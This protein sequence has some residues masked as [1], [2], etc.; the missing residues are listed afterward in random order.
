MFDAHGKNLAR[1]GAVV[2]LAGAAAG[3]TLAAAGPAA[4][5]DSSGVA[6]LGSFEHD[7][8]VT[9]PGQGAG[10]AGTV[11]LWYQGQKLTVYCIDI[12][13]PTHNG[14][15]YTETDWA[16]S[17]LSS[18]PDAGKIQWI[19]DHSYPSV[20]ASALAASA[21]LTGGLSQDEAAAGTQIAIWHY[22]DGV[23][24][25]SSDPRTS[26][27]A[28][29]L[30]QNAVQESQPQ[31]SLQLS[32]SNVAGTT[33]GRVGPI[34]VSTSASSVS[35]Q[36]SAPA[37]VSLSNSAG[38]SVQ[39]AVNNEQLY[40]NVPAG[41]APGD[42][43]VSASAT[44]DIPV[45]RAFTP[46][47]GLSQTMILAGTSPVSVS[48]VAQAQW[49]AAS[50]V[51]PAANAAADCKQGGIDVTLSNA[52]GQAWTTAV[53]G[54]SVTVPAGGSR[55][56]LVPVKQGATYRITVTGPNGFSKTFTGALKCQTSGPSAAPSASAAAGAPTP[57]ATP[58]GPGLAETGASSATPMI[59]G[60]GAALV[61]AGAGGVFLVRRRRNGRHAA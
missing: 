36:L 31:P 20:S 44:T 24:A 60:V 28:A 8:S 33:G 50:G 4:A 61:I 38:Q 16:D 51:V 35:L 45:G 11:A 59:G 58:S 34:T 7:Q 43:K 52:G 49:A 5:A 41:T 9:I 2:L 18:N 25:T 1:F 17:T 21:Q 12:K 30:E 47:D 42:A 40:L 57:S 29:W 55:T 37:G 32:P 15:R 23:D 54:Q 19:L 10:G 6:T 39:T 46:V 27:L 13:H 14:V 53:S 3:G 22:S 48:A 56:V 26:A